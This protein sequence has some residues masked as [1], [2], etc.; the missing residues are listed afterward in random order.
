M[1]PA[2]PIALKDLIQW[3]IHTSSQM[4]RRREWGEIKITIQQ[5]QILF[6]TEQRS[7]RDT[8]PQVGANVAANTTGQLSV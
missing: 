3:L 1:G 5:G 2:K 6:V 4:A 7:Y 8:L